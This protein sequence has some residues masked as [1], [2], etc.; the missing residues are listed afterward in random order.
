MEIGTGVSK[1]SLRIAY[2]TVQDPRD[3]RS[4]SGTHY[5]MARALERHCGEVSLIGPIKPFSWNLRKA[6]HRGIMAATG[7]NY[8]YAVPLIGKLGRLAGRRLSKGTYNV[9]FAPSSSAL[10]ARLSTQVP[11]VYLSDATVK[12]MVNYYPEFTNLSPSYLR[13]LDDIERAAIRNSRE[14]I[15]PSWW[16]ARSAILHYGADPGKVHI[17][18]FGANIESAPPR[19]AALRPLSRDRCRLL[20]VGVDWQRKGGEIAVQTLLSLERMGVPTELTIVGCKPPNDFRHPGLRVIPFIDKNEPQGRTQLHELWSKSDFF[21]LPT[22]AE[23]FSIALCEAS[24]FGL[25]ILSTHTGGLPELVLNGV[26][27]Y[28][29]PLEAGGDEYA[30]RVHDLWQNRDAYQALRASSRNQFESRLNWDAWGEQVSKVI[31]TAVG[32][33]QASNGRLPS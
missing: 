14:L 6:V 3:R 31:R 18:P 7:R 27:G 21:L 16:A 15:Y 11:I 4:W 22:R 2:L 20:F 33:S 19:E 10:I 30:H 29:F 24:A 1:G 13:A 17:V 28:L 5:L 9:V 12:I 32:S 25:P 8:P 26:N 23:C